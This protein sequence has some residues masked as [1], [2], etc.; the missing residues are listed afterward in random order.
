VLAQRA[1]LHDMQACLVQG[2]AQQRAIAEAERSKAR[3]ETEVSDLLRERTEVEERCAALQGKA[4]AA[5]GKDKVIAELRQ[6]VREQAEQ[7]D[8]LVA[9][10]GE[11]TMPGVLAMARQSL[12]RDSEEAELRRQIAELRAANARLE[13]KRVDAEKVFEEQLRQLRQG[14]TG[15]GGEDGEALRVQVARLQAALELSQQSMARSSVE[16]LRDKD[17]VIAGLEAE[18]AAARRGDKAHGLAPPAARAANSPD[19]LG[20]ITLVESDVD[21]GSSVTHEAASR[22]RASTRLGH[23]SF[24]RERELEDKLAEAA[25]R[26]ERLRRQLATLERIQKSAQG[27]A[28]AQEHQLQQAVQAIGTTSS[29]LEQTTAGLSLEVEEWRRKAEAASKQ[30]AKSKAQAEQAIG[31]LSDYDAA[32]TA[33][34]KELGECK[35]TLQLYHD[36]IVALAGAEDK[37][38]RDNAKWQEANHNKGVLPLSSHLKATNKLGQQ[39]AAERRHLERSLAISGKA[40]DAVR[41]ELEQVGVPPPAGRRASLEQVGVLPPA[42][43]RASPQPTRHASRP[44]FVEGLAC[45]RR[46]RWRT[47]RVAAGAWAT[48]VDV[49]G[50]GGQCQA[51]RARENHEWEMRVREQAAA[52]QEMDHRLRVH[53][54][55]GVVR[56]QELERSVRLLSTKSDTH[57]TAA[58]LSSEV[59]AL[60][61]AEQR[62]KNDLGFYRERAAAAE[63]ESKAGM[64]RVLALQ[65][66]LNSVQFAPGGSEQLVTTMSE[67]IEEQEAEVERLEGLLRVAKQQHDQQ[68]S[69]AHDAATALEERLAATQLVADTH[70]KRVLQLQGE[71]QALEDRARQWSEADMDCQDLLRRTQAQ[72]A[73]ADKAVEALTDQLGRAEELLVHARADHADKLHALSCKHGQEVLA[74]ADALVLGLARAERASSLRRLARLACALTAWCAYSCS[75]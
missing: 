19:S 10:L 67:Q 6:Q 70:Q 61:T 23:T 18:L 51:E 65:C 63:A 59:A 16:G 32:L 55:D 25:G 2:E 43:R 69:E 41:A 48:T 31:H 56:V 62:L 21:S 47:Q 75:R 44:V 49:A 3:L 29:T 73:A 26:E 72:K 58:T 8:A 60:R 45:A 15:G 30:A 17:E 66:R 12:Q 24:A 28:L 64:E 5:D 9:E 36:R 34:E 42:G 52:L 53:R 39:Y 13:A 35:A 22:A 27:T 54:D 14:E 20:T 38:V 33:M 74:C 4:D 7:L 40:L 50:C 37:V 57:K 1:K 11:G 68:A 71:V 46:R